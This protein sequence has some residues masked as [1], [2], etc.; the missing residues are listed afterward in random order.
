M[1]L[2]SAPSSGPFK[3]GPRLASL[4]VV[5]RVALGLGKPAAGNVGH[6]LTSWERPVGGLSRSPT[7]ALVL[8]CSAFEP[9]SQVSFW[10]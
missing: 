2:L 8:R 3:T 9:V 6:K 7:S 1:S 4:T 5:T 10:P